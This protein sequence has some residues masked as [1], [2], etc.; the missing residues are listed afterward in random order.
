MCRYDGKQ[1]TNKA[2]TGQDKT[3]Q[4]ETRPDEM[5]RCSTARGERKSRYVLHYTRVG[6]GKIFLRLPGLI[7]F[8]FNFLNFVN[9]A[10]GPA[11]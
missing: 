11:S 1:M 2:K 4:D 10:V 5:R 8:G 7:D 9:F 3:I 6:N